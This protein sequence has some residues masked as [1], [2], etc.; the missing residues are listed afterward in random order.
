M[1]EILNLSELQNMLKL[2]IS[3]QK[4]V[5]LEKKLRLW[6]DKLL[7]IP[8]K[9]QKVRVFSHKRGSLKGLQLFREWSKLSYFSGT[10]NYVC[11]QAVR[12]LG[13]FLVVFVLFFDSIPSFIAILKYI[14]FNQCRLFGGRMGWCVQTVRRFLCCKT[15]NFHM[16][17]Q[18]GVSWSY[19]LAKAFLLICRM[20]LVPNW[21]LF[22]ICFHLGWIFSFWVSFVWDLPF[23]DP[24]SMSSFFPY[25]PLLSP[26][27]PFPLSYILCPDLPLWIWAFISHLQAIWSS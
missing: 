18:S 11:K 21:D 6:L 7:L 10:T 2:R 23:L 15:L 25:F 14:L 16:V 22:S 26:S 3:G 20:P 1:W 5:F 27:F 17:P 24:P 4:I 9:D 12:S 8:E 19:T 13:S